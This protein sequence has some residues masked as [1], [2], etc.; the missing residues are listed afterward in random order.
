MS[1]IATLRIAKAKRKDGQLQ[2]ELEQTNSDTERKISLK[3]LGGCHPDLDAAFDDVA[4]YVREILEWPGNLY[5]NHMTVTGVSWSVSENTGVE[6]AVIS[7]Q[8]SLKGC[9]SPFCFNTPFLPFD[10]YNEEN[11]NQPVMP[12]GAQDALAALR[13]EVQA[14]IDGKRAQGDLFEQNSGLINPDNLSGPY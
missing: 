14:Y 13:A 10:L 8:A 9:N 5:S 1:N 12:D 7:A 2:V 6:G 3:S 11:E 4:P